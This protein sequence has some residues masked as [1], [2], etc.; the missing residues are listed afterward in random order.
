MVFIYFTFL[1]L[2]QK[3]EESCCERDNPDTQYQHSTVRISLLNNWYNW[4]IQEMWKKLRMARKLCACFAKVKFSG[5]NWGG[6]LPS[7]RSQ[8]EIA[9]AKASWI[10][11]DSLVFCA[12]RPDDYMHVW[13]TEQGQL[14]ELKNWKCM[15]L[16]PVTMNPVCSTSVALWFYCLTCKTGIIFSRL[17]VFWD[18]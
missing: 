3:E 10:V 9:S 1:T 8:T 17:K 12:G 4:R 16:E 11:L 14:S 13:L 15:N 18:Q 7:H 5:K 2:T 6:R